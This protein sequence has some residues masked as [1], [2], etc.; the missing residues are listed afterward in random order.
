MPSVNIF[1]G[2]SILL[3]RRTKSTYYMRNTTSLVTGLLLE[4]KADGDKQAKLA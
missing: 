4:Q 1:L 3:A 2:L